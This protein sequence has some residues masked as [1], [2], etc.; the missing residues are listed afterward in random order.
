MVDGLDN[1]MFAYNRHAKN[2]PDIKI[3]KNPDSYLTDRVPLLQ[4]LHVLVI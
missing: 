2:I 1:I 4:T 3:R